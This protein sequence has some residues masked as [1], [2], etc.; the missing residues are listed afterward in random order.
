MPCSASMGKGPYDLVQE[1]FSRHLTHTIW[2]VLS[3]QPRRPSES[4]CRHRKVEVDLPVRSSRRFS[5]HIEAEYHRQKG[6]ST[7]EITQSLNT[8][9]GIVNSAEGVSNKDKMV[10]SVFVTTAETALAFRRLD[11]QVTAR[12]DE[13]G[14]TRSRSTVAVEDAAEHAAHVREVK[15]VLFDGW[16]FATFL[17]TPLDRMPQNKSLRTD[18]YHAS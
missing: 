12:P 18:S 17:L 1:T 16:R 8:A 6:D 11:W 3:G 5:D 4:A 10:I 7:V 9:V 2:P 15:F 14:L 13:S